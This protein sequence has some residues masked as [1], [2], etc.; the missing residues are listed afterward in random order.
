[1]Q[2]SYRNGHVDLLFCT[3]R[4]LIYMRKVGVIFDL[5]SIHD[6]NGMC[7]SGYLTNRRLKRN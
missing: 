3:E 6:V 4:A 5:A 2:T 7:E 1:M